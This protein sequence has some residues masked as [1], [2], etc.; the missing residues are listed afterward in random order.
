M[1]SIRDLLAQNDP[2]RKMTADLGVVPIGVPLIMGPGAMT[3]ILII[4]DTQGPWICSA[5][6]FVNIF[7]VWMLFK[8]SNHI[9][10]LMGENGTRAFSKVASLFL[11][12]I[13]IKMVRFGIEG[14]LQ[15]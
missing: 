3:T 7:I 2:R 4:A 15:R 12:A 1:I 11:A 14:F 10:R 8:N 13:A 9:V 5:A 6:L